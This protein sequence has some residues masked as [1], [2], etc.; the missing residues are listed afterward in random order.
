[1]DATT[2]AT[3][4]VQVAPAHS[5]EQLFARFRT[6][7]QLWFVKATLADL[8][9]TRAGKGALVEHYQREQVRLTRELEVLQA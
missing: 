4:G 5:I 6:A 1:M 9:A 7:Q 3:V 2:V 8:H